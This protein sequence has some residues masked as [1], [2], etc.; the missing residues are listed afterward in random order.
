V[1]V[2]GGGETAA[3]EALHMASLASEVHLLYRRDRLSRVS[4]TLRRRLEASDRI[5]IR[6]HCEVLEI[7]GKDEPRAVES[8]KIVDTSTGQGSEL[9]V[10]AVFMAVG[11]EPQT[12]LLRE[13]GLRLDSQGYIVTEPNSSR[14]NIRHVYGAGDVTSGKYRQAVLAAAQGAMAALEIG[15]D[16]GL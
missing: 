8:L 16:R 3:V 15:E 2:V 12:G 13:S 7:C 4:E 10:Q 6:F 11:L 1:A 5:N 14:T 9:A